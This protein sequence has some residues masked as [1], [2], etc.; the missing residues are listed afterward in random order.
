MHPNIP[1][2]LH[3][4]PPRTLKDRKWWEKTKA[5]AKAKEKCLLELWGFSKSSQV[6]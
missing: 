1:K 2:P 5:T 4:M 3:G 6:S